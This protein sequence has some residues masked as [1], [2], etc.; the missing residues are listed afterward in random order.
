MTKRDPVKRATPATS[1]A[2]AHEY[3]PAAKRINVDDTTTEAVPMILEP[4]P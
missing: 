4:N 1:C 2:W 3:P